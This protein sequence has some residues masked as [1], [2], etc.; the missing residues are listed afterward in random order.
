VSWDAV[1]KA[2]E[3]LGRERNAVIKDWGGRLPVA[4]VYPNRYY[5]GMSNLGMHAIY[6]LL[7]RE[8]KLIC[9]RAFWEGSGLVVSIETQ[10]PLSDFAVLAFSIPYELDY[11]NI[12]LI[13]KDAGLPFFAAE[14][15]DAHPLVIAGGAAVTANPM[16]LAP[17]FDA[18][19]IGEAEVILPKLLEVVDKGLGRTKTL[20]ALAEIPGVYVPQMKPEGPVTRQF[21]PK[22]DENLASS[23]VI[24]PDTELGDL[25]LIEIA[26]GCAWSCRF[27]LATRIFCPVRYGG[28]ERILAQAKEGLKYRKRLGLVGAAVSGHPK[29]E[30]LV[31]ELQRMGAQISV[32]SLRIKP[33]HRTVLKAVL[34]SGAKTLTLAPEAGSE[35]LRR[36]INKGINEDDIM[37]AMAMVAELGVKQLKL[38]FM[39]GLPTET[40]ED[41]EAIVKL[42][43]RLNEMLGKGARLTLNVAPFVPK[44][45]TPFQWQP[46]ARLE[47][48]N[49]RLKQLKAGLEPAGIKVKAESPAWSEVQAILARGDKTLGSALAEMEAPTLAGFKRALA[50]CGVDGDYFAHTEWDANIK[51]PWSAVTSKEEVEMLRRETGG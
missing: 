30:P 9:E 13:L 41:I 37:R 18:V 19:A 34:E 10:R 25:Y 42:S 27:C 26:R 14:R 44:A 51:L 38:Y 16:P 7:N 32:S 36:L 29:I 17:F 50:K 22:L 28:L 8:N 6:R 40:D 3:Q 46:M 20:E 11:F 21:V 39:I 15:G 4:L 33:L 47:V 24:S 45:G 1:K 35:R 23:A 5:I 12:P 2:R 43:R 31:L 49:S 48:V